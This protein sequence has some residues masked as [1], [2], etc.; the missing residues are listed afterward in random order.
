[1]KILLSFDVEEFDMP[2]EY[3]QSISLDEQLAVGLAGLKELIPVW[4][5]YNTTT[6]LFTTAQ[7]AKAY[8]DIMKSLASNHEIAL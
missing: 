6:T 1:M 4:E 2:L 3:G 5:H 8:P 7:F